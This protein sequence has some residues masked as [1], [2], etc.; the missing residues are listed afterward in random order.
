MPRGGINPK[1]MLWQLDQALS[2]KFAALAL[3]ENPWWDGRSE[4][5]T[6][7]NKTDHTDEEHAAIPDLDAKTT[8]ESLPAEL[9]LDI[10]VHLPVNQIQ[11]CLG[12]S[13]DF[14]EL[15]E[16]QANKKTLL[17]P[18]RERFN[19]Q[20]LEE[21]NYLVGVTPEPNLLRFLFAFLSRRGI[22]KN[23]TNNQVLMGWA[24][25][26]WAENCS[27]EFRKLARRG[28]WY[29]PRA[30][31]NYLCKI[32]E[33]LLQIY[34]DVNCPRQLR[35]WSPSGYYAPTVGHFLAH[36]DTPERSSND[37]VDLNYLID[38]L[39]LPL[40][41]EQLRQWYLDIAEHREPA[42]PAHPRSIKDKSDRHGLLRIPTEEDPSLDCPEFPVTE[43][44]TWERDR[45]T[46]DPV[47]HGGCCTTKKLSRILG[48][49]FQNLPRGV[50][51]CA[52][53]KWARDLIRQA[54]KRKTMVLTEE[55]RVAVLEQ[56]YLF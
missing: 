40:S 56:L 43:I 16:T 7:C 42:L 25:H 11:R 6:I 32:G 23:V 35:Y 21:V 20:C 55:Q 18:A 52:R 37:Q 10:L 48:V 30:L 36:I 47:H 12:V 46:D 14:Q 15:I 28:I 22:W 2:N 4:L 3:L 34:I 26:R 13:K 33:L 41:R 54:R 27:P 38:G 53:T 51:I 8:L 44:L 39:G 29:L 1:K 24:V 19:Q 31:W 17:T 49:K 45:V 5:C 9:R 50:G